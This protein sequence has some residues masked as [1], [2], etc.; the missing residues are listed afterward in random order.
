LL[1]ENG[2]NGSEI[3]G[4]QL[5]IEFL[6]ILKE[7]GEKGCAPLLIRNIPARVAEEFEKKIMSDPMHHGETDREVRDKEILN[8]MLRTIERNEKKE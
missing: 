4:K 3:E 1:H 8:F 6:K 7:D 5:L 2:T